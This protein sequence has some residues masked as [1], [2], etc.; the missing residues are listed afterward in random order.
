MTVAL[1][2]DVPMPPGS[3]MMLPPQ[4]GAVIGSDWPLALL[5]TKV[6]IETAGCTTLK[7]TAFELIE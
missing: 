6:F 1:G 3:W 4:V 2:C 5:G 7:V